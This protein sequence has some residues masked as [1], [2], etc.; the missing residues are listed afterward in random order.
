M[1]YGY[2]A[3]TVWKDHTIVWK[4]VC[5]IVKRKIRNGR[6]KINGSWYYPNDLHLEYDGRCDHHWFYFGI[7]HD[8]FAAVSLHS[9]VMEGDESHIIDGKL[10][11][12]FWYQK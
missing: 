4:G 6:V 11:W 1:F 9:P 3:E 2:N 5:V 10:P 12:L 7:Y 8:L